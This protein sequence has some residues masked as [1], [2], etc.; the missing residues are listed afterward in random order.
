MPKPTAN[1]SKSLRRTASMR[2]KKM[3]AIQQ[4]PGVY[5]CVC[6]VTH[7]YATV[8]LLAEV[9]Y[10]FCIYT[11]ATV[12]AVTPRDSQMSDRD[13]SASKKQLSK[14]GA[15]SGADLEQENLDLKREVGISRLPAT[16]VCSTFNMMLHMSL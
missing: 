1:Q 9:S 5:V 16:Y 13:A 7:T 6:P 10:I 12:L 4:P 3:H 14:S 8:C 2:R 11:D 15:P